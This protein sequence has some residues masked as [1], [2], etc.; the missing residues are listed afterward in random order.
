MSFEDGQ[1][2]VSWVLG[3]QE[4]PFGMKTIRVLM[5]SGPYGSAKGYVASL[6]YCNRHRLIPGYRFRFK[7]AKR[8]GDE[9]LKD[10]NGRYRY[11]VLMYPGGNYKQGRDG[12]GSDVAA[13]RRFVRRGGGYYGTCGGCGAV[14]GRIVN[15]DG[16]PYSNSPDERSLQLLP[17]LHA[18]QGWFTGYFCGLLTPEGTRLTG[19]GGEQISMLGKGT[20]LFY[21]RGKPHGHTDLFFPFNNHKGPHGRRSWPSAPA[22]AREPFQPKYDTMRDGGGQQ[23]YRSLVRSTYG[24]GRVLVG[25]THVEG[26]SPTGHSWFPRWVGGGVVWAAGYEPPFTSYILGSDRGEHAMGKRDPD[27]AGRRVRSLVQAERVTHSGR[28]SAIRVLHAGKGPVTVSLWRGAK[29]PVEKLFASEPNLVRLV[30]RQWLT[31]ELERPVRVHAGERIWLGVETKN[32]SQRI[33]GR[34]YPALGR[35]TLERRAFTE[36]AEDYVA[37]I[38]ARVEFT[39]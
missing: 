8:I 17:Q 35:R 2:A 24:R 22:K 3:C 1:S 21:P 15:R 38:Y 30:R 20:Y 10:R 28:V 27:L 5:Y 12:E 9:V 25:Q 29:K 4:T 37:S 39:D 31:F 34:R 6:A 18:E 36:K 33:F 23:K 19:Y 32:K 7:L 14:I 13:V 16:S 11:D 26:G